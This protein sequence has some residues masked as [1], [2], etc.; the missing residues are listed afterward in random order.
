[1]IVKWFL[2]RYSCMHT[3]VR[4]FG[5]AILLAF[6]ITAIGLSGCATA[7]HVEEP[8]IPNDFRQVVP[9]TNL[10]GKWILPV[11]I[12]DVELNL[13]LDTGTTQVALFENNS[14]Q[15]FFSNTNSFTKTR[16]FDESGPSM[17]SKLMKNATLRMDGFFDQN[18]NVTLFESAQSPIFPWHTEKIHGLIGFELLSKY[19]VRIDNRKM[20]AT[21]MKGGTLTRSTD[22]HYF[23]IKLI[24]KIPAFEGRLRFPHAGKDE[25]LYVMIDTGSNISIIIHTSVDVTANIDTPVKKAYI[26]S[27][28]GLDQY[29]KI[30]DVLITT[31]KGN[32]SYTAEAHVKTIAKITTRATIGMPSLSDDIIEISYKS[33]F[34][35]TGDQVDPPS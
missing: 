2:E 14:T 20:L 34:I 18:V 19:D 10:A 3:F 27:I 29:T 12:N 33:K 6:S 30:A 32:F 7:P 28:S 13:I 5:H 22:K 15:A 31:T 1:M 16:A 23:P 17:R 21:F 35:S 9:F 25:K 4:F 11:V 26:H 24:G 8:S